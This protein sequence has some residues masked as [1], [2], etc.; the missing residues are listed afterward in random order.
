[1]T[2]ITAAI[3]LILVM[4]PL[5]NIPIFLSFLRS[6]DKRRRQQIILRETFI[7][8]VILMLF[9]FYGRYILSGMQISMPALTIAG[10]MILFLIS[11]KMIF[12]DDKDEAALK[13]QGEPLIVPLAV[14]MIAGPSTMAMV[15]LIATRDPSRMGSWAAAL[16]IAWVVSTLVI[17]SG[18]FL[19]K[20]LGNA[21]LIAMERLMGMILTTMAVQ[22]FLSGVATFFHLL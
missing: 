1:M 19:R 15:M 2:I 11:I 7:A 22:M 5:G 14:P 6:V 12:P 18:E 20:I 10:G 13:Q 17:L 4:D 16:F 9:M 8:L 21:G 3:T